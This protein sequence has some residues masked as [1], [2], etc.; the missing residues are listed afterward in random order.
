MEDKSEVIAEGNMYKICI[1]VILVQIVAENKEAKRVDDVSNIKT[2]FVVP[3]R[4]LFHFKR[5]YFG[6]CTEHV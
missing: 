2:A 4:G 3:S 1:F 5:I 6:L